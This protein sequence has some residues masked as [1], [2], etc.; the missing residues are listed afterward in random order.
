MRPWGSALDS[1]ICHS[2]STVPYSPPRFLLRRLTSVDSLLKPLCPLAWRSVHSGR[3][4]GKRKENLG[5]LPHH[6]PAG[7]GT[8]G[9]EPSSC[10]IT[11]MGCPT[12]RTLSVSRD[13]VLS[14]LES[15]SCGSSV[16]TA[17]DTRGAQWLPKLLVPGCFQP[18]VG[19][20]SSAH[21]C[22]SPLHYTPSSIPLTVH[23]FPPGIWTYSGSR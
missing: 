2:E 5:Y 14:P 21:P 4:A 17:K 16:L 1:S 15:L 22:K 6:T 7:Q 8:A 12:P 19:S 11:A 3:Q 20:L 18:S 9:S 10:A 23:F 13:S